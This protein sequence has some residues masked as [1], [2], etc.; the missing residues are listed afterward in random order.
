[1]QSLRA[2]TSGSRVASRRMHASSVKP[3]SSRPAASGPSRRSTVKVEA[4]KGQKG[5]TGVVPGQAEAMRIEP[6]CPEVDPDN[7]EFVVF[8]RA[9][10][11]MD[12]KMKVKMNA[13]PWVPLTIVKGGQAA[14][15]LVKA[16]ENEW[17][18]KL[19]GKTLIKNIGM[20]CYKD[21]DSIER[22][23]KQGQPNLR[24]VPSSNFQYAFK[25]R[26]KSV[27]KDWYKSDGITIFPAESQLNRTALDD[28]K[29]FYSPETFGKMFAA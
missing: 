5:R 10:D 7:A 1:M 25:I 23:L 19:Y 2:S 27:P 14:N 12:E 4:K 15:F 24:N 13:S 16:M 9:V 11:Y 3:F 28:L 17:G 22:G 8:I 21:R 26:D 20:A 18:R 29:T 6:P